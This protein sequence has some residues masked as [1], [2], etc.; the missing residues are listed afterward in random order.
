[1]AGDGEALVHVPVQI[2]QLNLDWQW[3]RL[4]GLCVGIYD[5]PHS[6]PQLVED[7][8]YVV[9]TQDIRTGT[10]RALEAAHVSEDT[11]ASRTSRAEP[12]HG[13]LL[14]SREGTYFGIAAEVPPATRVCLGQRMVLIRPDPNKL[15][16]RY[17]LYWLNSPALAGLIHGRKDGS[18][19]ERLNLP[20]IRALP[21]PIRSLQDQ[22]WV[23]SLLGGLDDRILANERKSQSLEET[24]RA[25]FKSWFI[26]FDPV[27][28]NA[29]RLSIGSSSKL[30]VLFPDTFADDG[31]PMAGWRNG[32]LGE[33]ATISK[34]LLDPR[35]FPEE[36][37]LHYSIPA[38]DNCRKPVYETGASIGSTKFEVPSGSV[39]LSKLNPDTPRVWFVP[40][41]KATL[42]QICSTEFMVMQAT[43]MASPEY[44]YCLLGQQ[45]FQ[46]HLQALVTGT[47]GSHQRVRPDAALCIR[48][49]IPSAPVMKAFQELVRPLL[50]KVQLSEAQSRTLAALRD[51]LLPKLLSGEIRVPDAE[52]M[53]EEAGV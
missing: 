22:A 3:E 2:R 8:P 42:R 24:V 26:D 14:Y 53:L 50:Q 34:N 32:T 19:A 52:R 13:D 36:S 49:T 47:S 28:F 40:S 20:T 5:C 31:V 41:T 17:L 38:F 29:E 10:F 16:H 46:Q 21:V 4:D 45:A 51:A 12:R 48:T 1:M 11:Y 7:G 44:L 25:M 33:V 15:H 27:N 30:Q 37:F 35:R 39:L 18:V 9:R 6:T 23:S 43:G